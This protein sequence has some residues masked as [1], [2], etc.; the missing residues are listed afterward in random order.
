LLE[1]AMVYLPVILKAKRLTKAGIRTM[2]ASNLNKE[3]IMD[4]DTGKSTPENQKQE[5]G[6]DDI[7]GRLFMPLCA[8]FV[9][10][11]ALLGE[12]LCLFIWDLF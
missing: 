8:V 11:M 2:E 9:W 4:D 10:S 5:E 7:L 3:V 1:I 12:W 6:Q